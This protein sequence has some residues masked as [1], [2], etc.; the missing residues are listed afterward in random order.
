MGLEADVVVG[1]LLRHR[2]RLVSV[3]AA[4]VRNAHDADD[5]FQQVVMSAI[6]H[7]GE[8]RDA[9]HLLPWSIRVLRQRAIDLARKRQLRSL[10]DEVLDLLEAEWC[11]PDADR[12]DRAENLW[13]CIGQ[14]TNTVQS[15]LV[16]RYFD[17]MT[18]QAIADRLRRKPDAVYQ[19]LS[20]AHRALRSCVEIESGYEPDSRIVPV[21]VEE[22][23]P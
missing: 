6:E 8:I 14:L 4:H 17:G 18:V 23:Q 15:V 12:I 1:T 19:M 13:R 5:L 9:D 10:S 16:M 22:E 2:Q 3:A 21:P 7:R 11:E 20:R